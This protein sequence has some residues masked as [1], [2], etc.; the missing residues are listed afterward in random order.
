M[1]Q[2]VRYEGG[3]GLHAHSV[4]FFSARGCGYKK[5]KGF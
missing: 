1:Q 2:D 5:K 4:W 3:I